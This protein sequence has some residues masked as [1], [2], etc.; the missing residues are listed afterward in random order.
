VSQPTEPL[1][2]QLKEITETLVRRM[3]YTEGLWDLTIEFHFGAGQF[4][5]SPE[6]VLPG[7]FVGVSRIGLTKSEKAGPHTVDAAALTSKRPALKK[8]RSKG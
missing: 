8:K 1:F 2:F 4:G 7:G 6:S 5:P 3:G